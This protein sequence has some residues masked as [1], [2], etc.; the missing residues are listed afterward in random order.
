MS[1]RDNYSLSHS[2]FFILV[3]PEYCSALT[4]VRD[5]FCASETYTTIPVL[6]LRCSDV[7]CI[8]HYSSGENIY[9]AVHLR[10]TA[11]PPST[12]CC[13]KKICRL[14]TTRIVDRISWPYQLV[15]FHDQPPALNCSAQVGRA[16]GHVMVT[17]T[18]P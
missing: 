9:F 6:H 12:H 1:R 15:F 18:N 2:Y 5:L 14:D 11:Y 16:P 8:Q 3:S 7:L 10:H 4:F 17:T 13:N